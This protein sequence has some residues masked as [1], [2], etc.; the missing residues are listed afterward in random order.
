MPNLACIYKDAFLK[1]PDVSSINKDIPRKT[2]KRRI[3]VPNSSGYCRESRGL[4][5]ASLVEDTP[6][7]S[8][9]SSLSILLPSLCA[10]GTSF[11]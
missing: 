3:D 1:A 4:R 9:L 8:V 7:G 11:S 5:S 6:L 10:R 2:V